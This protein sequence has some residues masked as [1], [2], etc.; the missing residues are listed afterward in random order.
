MPTPIDR[1]PSGNTRTAKQNYTA[2]VYGNEKGSVGFGHIHEKGDVTSG[3]SLRTPEAK[4]HMLFEIDGPRKGYTQLCQPGNLSINAG[5]ANTEAAET[6]S[7]V[8]ENGNISITATNGKIR[9]QGTDI[10]IIAVGEG[11]S[12]G[13]IR[14]KATETIETVSKKTLMTSSAFFRIASTGIGEIT[15]N[16][17][18]QMYGSIFRGISDGCILK[19]SKVGGQRYA[20]GSIALT[21]AQAVAQ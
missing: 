9:L 17:V 11:G 5:L 6:I 12:K 21:T 7:V 18:L 16:T 3:V 1:L 8:S 10:E 20:L 13:N 14:L 2:I 4:H 15:A 19:N